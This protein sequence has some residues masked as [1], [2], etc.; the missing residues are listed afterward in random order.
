M[1]TKEFL[2]V[3]DPS[4]RIRAYAELAPASTML[5]FPEPEQLAVVSLLFA[6]VTAAVNAPFAFNNEMIINYIQ[7]LIFE[8]MKGAIQSAPTG[9]PDA[10]HG[11]PASFC[12]SWKASFLSSPLPGLCNSVS[13]WISPAGL[14]SMSIT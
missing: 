4:G 12:S 3:N 2:A 9:Q 11:S 10:R 5:L 8:G 13:R 1:F 14:R 6:Q 7:L